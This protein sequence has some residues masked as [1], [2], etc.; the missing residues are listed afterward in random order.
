MDTF[1][2]NGKRVLEP[3]VGSSPIPAELDHVDVDGTAHNSELPPHVQWPHSTSRPSKSAV[4][5]MT[6]SGIA[7]RR[8]ITGS[9][10]CCGRGDV[11]LSRTYNH[12]M[13]VLQLAWSPPF[14]PFSIHFDGNHFESAKLAM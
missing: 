4:S 10:P 13:M 14:E 9:C 2:I 5:H 1:A 7:K 3:Y 12:Q 6:A 11:A 8:K